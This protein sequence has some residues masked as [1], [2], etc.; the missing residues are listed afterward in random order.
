[1][2]IAESLV[3]SLFKMI[4]RQEFLYGAQCTYNYLISHLFLFTINTG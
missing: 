4:L 3:I 1:M 2:V